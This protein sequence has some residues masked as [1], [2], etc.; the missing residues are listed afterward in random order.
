MAGLAGDGDPLVMAAVPVTVDADKASLLM[1]VR[2]QV[3]RFNPV[4]TGRGVPT[5]LQG[6]GRAVFPIVIMLIAAMVVAACIITVMATQALAVCGRDK[7]VAAQGTILESQM[8]GAAAGAVGDGGI[9][10]PFGI[11]V[12]AQA[13]AAEHVVGQSKRAGKRVSDRYVRRCVQAAIRAKMTANGVDFVGEGEMERAGCG[14]HLFW[15]TTTAGCSHPV[16]MAR[17]S[18]QSG[19]GCVGMAFVVDAAM[20]RSAGKLMRRIELNLV[21]TSP[22]TDFYRWRYR[23]L[24]DLLLSGFRRVSLLGSAAAE[25]Y[26]DYEA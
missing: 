19:M 2:S 17:A 21:M 15:M 26:N 5:G 22:A 12:T 11:H 6:V 7:D 24:D 16:R 23:W 4:G 8:A 13:A 14:L 1:D 20:T 25:Q 18:N 10:V 9:V 3:V